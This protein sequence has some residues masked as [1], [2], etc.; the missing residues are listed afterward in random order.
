[1]LQ[2]CDSRHQ[3]VPSLL[4]L[5]L[6][7]N[8]G[9]LNFSN[10]QTA[11]HL[12]RC[13]K[14]SACNSSKVSDIKILYHLYSLLWNQHHSVLHNIYC[15]NPETGWYIRVAAVFLTRQNSWHSENFVSQRGKGQRAFTAFVPGLHCTKDVNAH[16]KKRSGLRL[17]DAIG[18]GL[19]FKTFMVWRYLDWNSHTLKAFNEHNSG[20][21][22]HLNVLTDDRADVPGVPYSCVGLTA[23]IITCS[24]HVNVCVCGISRWLWRQPPTCLTAEPGTSPLRPLPCLHRGCRMPH[25]RLWQL[26]TMRELKAE[27]IEKGRSCLYR[28]CTKRIDALFK[29]KT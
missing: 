4:P 12:R 8:T 1:M 19:G 26:H 29:T 11:L 15:P 24:S 13:Y 2:I 28:E 10:F 7:L 27:M 21:V 16:C 25:P 14:T 5:A 6:T 3:R 17:Y 22:F 9:A 18:T 23:Y 20:A